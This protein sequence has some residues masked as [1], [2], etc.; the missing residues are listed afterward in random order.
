MLSKIENFF[1]MASNLRLKS[2]LKFYR[3]KYLVKVDNTFH[4]F[5]LKNG[6]NVT[7]NKSEG[8]LTTLYEVFM[9]E[10]Y[11]FGEDSNKEIN[12]LDIGANVGYFSMYVAKKF[13]NARV[14]AFEPFP[15]TYKRL[16]KHLE[17]NGLSK[18]KALNYAVSDFNGPSEFYAFEWSGCNTLIDGDYDK[19]QYETTTVECIS[20]DK[21]AEITGADKIEYAKIDC[22]GSEY[23]IFLNSSDESIKSVRKYIME[24]HDSDKYGINDLAVRLEKLGYTVRHTTNLLTAEQN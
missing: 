17:M 8:D 5:S 6:L 11:K 7:V 12:I 4:G 16:N 13:P 9:D 2:L 24:V 14:F 23:P 22:E 19:G 21:I 20:F 15:K 1:K 18:V 3:L 10:D